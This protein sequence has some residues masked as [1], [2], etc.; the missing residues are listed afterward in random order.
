MS[1]GD[2][3]TRQ[4]SFGHNIFKVLLGSS[5][6]TVIALIC[7]PIITRLFEPAA[8]G[9]AAF[10]V[11]TMGIISP[12]LALRY[13]QAIIPARAKSESVNV[14]CLSFL[15]LFFNTI[16]IAVI[17]YALNSYLFTHEKLKHVLE[18]AWVLP[19]GIFI[20]GAFTTLNIWM[21]KHGRFSTI[22]WASLISGGTASAVS[23]GL[24]V[25]G[26]TSG[27]SLLLSA[28]LGN[29]FGLLALVCVFLIN[30]LHLLRR[31]S[32]RRRIASVAIKFK[33]FPVYGVWSSILGNGTFLLPTILMG[34]FFSIDFVGLFALAFRLLQM[35]AAFIGSAISQAYFK[36]LDDLRRKN[37]AQDFVE[38][39]ASNLLVVS[40]YPFLGLCIMGEV[41]FS[42]V[43]GENWSEAGYFAQ[44]LSMGAW[45]T[46]VSG[47]LAPTFSVYQKQSLQLRFQILN[48]VLRMLCFAIAVY[49]SS[50]FALVAL[51]GISSFLVYGYKTYLTLD[52]VGAKA[53]NVA[54]Q[55]WWSVA[56]IFFF[57]GILAIL[58]NQGLHVLWQLLF[59]AIS[60]S[61]LIGANLYFGNLTANLRIKV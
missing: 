50:G 24:G 60:Y 3:F 15:L 35:P 51:F 46:F 9:V 42:F 49:L 17:L 61:F 53:R 5:S 23:V 36:T 57:V 33:H 45:L 10:F 19:Y 22:G 21:V 25:F 43:F 30:D 7:A 18:Y 27:G 52:I 40:L 39:L 28:I 37:R 59:A 4:Y 12:V 48:F 14:F 54:R 34:V 41:F 31:A 32:T 11:A 8:Y 44:I 6:A 13:E 38:N 20:Y 56:A 55:T 2:R 1:S 29:F 26:H 58:V 47:A 16:V